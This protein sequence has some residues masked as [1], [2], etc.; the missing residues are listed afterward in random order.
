[1]TYTQNILKKFDTCTSEDISKGKDWYP[2]ATSYAKSISP[3]SPERGAGV[4]AVLSP[5]TPW[6]KNLEYAAKVIK[7]V[8]SGSNIKPSIGG[9]YQNLE[10]AWSIAKGAEVVSV[11]TSGTR[12]ERWLKVQRFYQNFIGNLDCVTVDVWAARVA[13]PDCQEQIGGKL[14]LSLERSYQD[15]AKKVNINPRDLQAVVWL[16][17]RNGN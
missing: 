10:K 16:K 17:E 12:S 7:A 4:I 14:Y 1:M 5:R 2:W 8:D 3:S 11:L 6:E 9:T 15:A 13:F